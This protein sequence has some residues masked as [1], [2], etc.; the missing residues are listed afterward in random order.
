MEFM[1]V[2]ASQAHGIL[3]KEENGMSP[4]SSSLS[5]ILE[6]RRVNT[7]AE[8]NGNGSNVGDVLSR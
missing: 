4:A 3:V 5:E 7:T 1:E 6:V 2:G 8:R